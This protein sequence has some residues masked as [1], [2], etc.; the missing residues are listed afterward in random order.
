LLQDSV[1]TGALL[2]IIRDACAAILTL[3]DGIDQESLAASRITRT[4]VVRQIGIVC[5]TAADLPI[6]TRSLLERLDWDAWSVTSRELRRG[7][8]EAASAMWFAARSLAPATLLWLQTY[9]KHLP[10]VFSYRV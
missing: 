6:D 8:D 5:R 7:G 1:I 10:D 4:E 2:D 3:T 9:R